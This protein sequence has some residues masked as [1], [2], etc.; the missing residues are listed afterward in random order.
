VFG[1]AA[2]ETKSERS[3]HGIKETLST[4]AEQCSLFGPVGRQMCGQSA[5]FLDIELWWLPTIDDCGGDVRCEPGEA[6][7]RV[8]VSGRDPLLARD[9]VARR[10][11]H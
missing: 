8:D 10:R 3:I 1:D 2:P 9:V 5:E 4:K 6:E 7:Q 11:A